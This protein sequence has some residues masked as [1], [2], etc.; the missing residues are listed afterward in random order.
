MDLNEGYETLR[1]SNSKAA[2]ICILNICYRWDP[3]LGCAFYSYFIL[4]MLPT[5][6]TNARSEPCCLSISLKNYCK[7]SVHQK[8]GSLFLFPASQFPLQSLCYHVSVAAY[9]IYGMLQAHRIFIAFVSV[10]NGSFLS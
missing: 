2:F 7:F 8:A 4:Q 5:L 3:V 9:Y 1:R 6:H 10:I